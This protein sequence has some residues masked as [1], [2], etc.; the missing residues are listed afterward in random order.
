MHNE[1]AGKWLPN[2]CVPDVCPSLQPI[3]LL[4]DRRVSLSAAYCFAGLVGL[5]ATDAFFF[6]V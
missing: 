2:V 5:F 4:C 6:T 3:A 1:L